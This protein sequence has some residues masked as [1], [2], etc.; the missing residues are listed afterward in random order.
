MRRTPAALTTLLVAL[1]LLAVAA[2]A[3]A[4]GPQSEHDRIVAHWT[5][6]RMRAAVPR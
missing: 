6:V 1:S 4:R 3:A 2:P 5:P